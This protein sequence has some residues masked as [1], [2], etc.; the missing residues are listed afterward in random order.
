MKEQKTEICLQ[1]CEKLIDGRKYLIAADTFTGLVRSRNEDNYAYV[2]DP[3]GK[4][5][6]AVVADGIGSTRNGD[7]ASDSVVRMLVHAW[8]N[9]QLP[10]R[11]PRHAVKKFLYSKSEENT[12]LK[13]LIG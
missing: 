1:P 10:A 6:L 4:Y 5:L 3:S 11:N 2:W 12:L 8:Q 7:L 13:I 9:W